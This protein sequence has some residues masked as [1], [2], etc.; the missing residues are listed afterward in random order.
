MESILQ[1]AQIS[2]QIHIYLQ[3]TK[4][5]FN[6]MYV[7]Q[8]ETYIYIVISSI[9]LAF[10]AISWN[11]WLSWFINWW[12]SCATTINKWSKTKV[13]YLRFLNTVIF[14]FIQEQL[15]RLYLSFEMFKFILMNVQHA[16]EHVILP[17]V[18]Y[19]LISLHF[20]DH[21]ICL[22]IMVLLHKYLHKFVQLQI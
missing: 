5:L 2:H 9:F 7:F 10:G 12:S 19:W 21:L 14:S 6:N 4:I 1:V 11:T 18:V 8:I 16:Q 22:W 20:N 13:I 3:K 17:C 15:V